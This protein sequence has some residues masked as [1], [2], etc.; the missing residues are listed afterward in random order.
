MTDAHAADPNAV[1]VTEPGNNLLTEVRLDALGLHESIAD[2]LRERG[3]SHATPIQADTLPLALAGRDIAGQANTGTGKTAAFLLATLDRLLRQSAAPSERAPS[4]AAQPRALILAPTRELADQIYQDALPLASRTGL[5]CVVCYGGTGYESQ[6]EALA[7][8][9]DVLIGTPG[10]L[11]DYY[12][13]KVYTLKAIEVAVLDE[14]DRMFDLGFID[15]VRYLF[16]KMPPATARQ[17]L[18]FS[19]TLSHRVL[20]LAYE[21]M[22]APELV[23]TDVDTVNI[24]AIA[25]KLYHVSKDDKTGLLIGL[26]RELEQ[27]RTL[28]FI[29]TKRVAE[30]LEDTLNA[31]GFSAATLSGDVAQNKR[32]RLLADFKNGALPIL[33]ATD[34]AARGLHIPDVSHVINYDLPQDAQD[35]VHRIGRTARAGNTGHAISFACEEYVYSL[36]DIEAYIEHKIAAEMPPDNLLVDDYVRAAPRRRRAG[37]GRGRPRRGNGKPRGSR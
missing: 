35:Y 17:N 14:A 7:A 24:E 37:G 2:G 26:L 10:R 32:L 22:N 16:R 15:D 34:V 18:L 21:H 29:N 12:K 6:R 23:R 4:G 36:P 9:V 25:Q 30:H 13:Q 19:A 33:V 20:E 8:G 3:F 5:K 11:I 28:V 27:A 1:E 31:N